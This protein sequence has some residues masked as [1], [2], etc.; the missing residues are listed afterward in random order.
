MTLEPRFL[1]GPAGPVFALHMAP[2]GGAGGRGV[3]L[4]PPFA[5]E[6]NR[7][8]RML[9]LQARAL[10]R[11]G[12]GALCLDPYGTGDSAGELREARWE[13]W[14]GDVQAAIAWLRQA[15]YGGITLLGLRLGALLAAEAARAPELGIGRLVLWQPVVNGETFL[16]QVLRLRIAADLQT[17]GAAK[18]TTGELRAAMRVGETV[19]LAGYELGG[20]LAQAIDRLRLA[21]L[22]PPAGTQVHWLE[23]AAEPASEPAPASRAAIEAWR[24]QGLPVAFEAVAGE[25]FWTLQDTTLAPALLDATLRALDHGEAHP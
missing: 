4:L 3:V 11:A 1:D 18:T 16:T 20:G 24:G 8:R 6:M 10:A 19:E 2:T 22:V 14:L 7:S 15:G 12:I 5:E 17:P 23:V 25:P 13:T 21:D 9:V